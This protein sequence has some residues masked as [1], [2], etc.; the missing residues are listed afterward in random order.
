M[1]H[2]DDHARALADGIEAALPGWV[3]RCVGR[4]LP[5]PGEEAAD[6]GTRAAVEV[7]GAVRQLLALDIDEQRTTPLTLL[8]DAVRYPAEVLRG[9][10]VLPVERDPFSRERF[11][12]DDYDLTPATFADVDPSLADVGLAWGAAK[13]WEHKRRHRA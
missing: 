8:R 4:Y 1:A 9:A 6:A 2:M 7:G 10:G 13:A 5:D 3:V 11:P 12:D